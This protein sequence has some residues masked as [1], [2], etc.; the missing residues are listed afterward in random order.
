[1]PGAA[2][3]G[4]PMPMKV[5]GIP[6]APAPGGASHWPVRFADPSYSPKIHY[7]DANGAIVGNAAN[8][9]GADRGTR[10]HAGIDL[11][12]RKGD[13]VIAIADGTVVGKQG[14]SGA[15]AKALVVDHG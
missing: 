1:D 10:V 8:R 11:Y 12:G 6:F 4:D 13:D 15:N 2:P 9:F 7:R 5:D 14:W 3:P